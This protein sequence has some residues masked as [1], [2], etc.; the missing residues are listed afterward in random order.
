MGWIKTKKPSHA[1]VPLNNA[2]SSLF[3]SSSL[4]FVSPF[5]T[6]LLCLLLF[7]AWF[8]AYIFVVTKLFIR[9]S[10]HHF[11]DLDLG[12]GRRSRMQSVS[13]ASIWSMIRWYEIQYKDN[14]S[15][16]LFIKLSQI[17][18]HLTIKGYQPHFCRPYTTE[19]LWQIT[20]FSEEWERSCTH[21][22]PNPTKWLANNDELSFLDLK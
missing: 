15:K 21:F 18:R 17:I 4:F 22:S 5:L 3:K 13:S 9:E 7:S 12:E 16:H 20:F 2:L 11:I 10:M 1:T 14:F 8:H 19:C 6:L